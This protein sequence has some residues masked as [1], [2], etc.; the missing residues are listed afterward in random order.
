MPLNT[1]F[2]NMAQE[3]Y[4]ERYGMR[5]LAKT[6]KNLIL[7]GDLPL[8]QEWDKTISPWAMSPRMGENAHYQNDLINRCWM[9]PDI[10]TMKGI[11]ESQPFEDEYIVRTS[12]AAQPQ[13]EFP[14]IVMCG[15]GGQGVALPN[16][17]WTGRIS[18]DQEATDANFGKVKT[19]F[20]MLTEFEYKRLAWL[21]R[22]FV[23]SEGHNS[24]NYGTARWN[25]GSWYDLGD[26]TDAMYTD[27]LAGTKSIT[28]IKFVPYYASGESSP[29]ERRVI[30]STG[31]LSLA[32]TQPLDGSAEGLGI[33]APY[34]T[35]YIDYSLTAFANYATSDYENNIYTCALGSTGIGLSNFRCK[36]STSEWFASTAEWAD[37]RP[38]WG[39]DGN[40]TES[41]YFNGIGTDSTFWKTEGLSSSNWMYMYFR[42]R[43]DESLLNTKDKIRDYILTQAAYLG[44]WFVERS[45]IA[46]S[47]E[48]S[49]NNPDAY[50]GVI[51]SD[52]L[53]HGQYQKGSEIDAPNA[54]WVNP[55]EESPYIPYVPDPDPDPTDYDEELQTRLTFYSTD[56]SRGTADYLMTSQALGELLAVLSWYKT[57]EAAGDVPEGTCVTLFGTT[58]PLE[59]VSNI[60]LYP[61]DLDQAYPNWAGGGNGSPCGYTGIYMAANQG[62][63]VGNTELVVTDSPPTSDP[64]YIHVHSFSDIMQINWG[65]SIPVFECKSMG[66]FQRYKSFLDYEPY[67]SAELYVP[68]CGS[69]KIDPE[70]FT[71]Q[72]VGVMYSLS[73]TDG[74]VRADVYRNGLCVDSLTG[75]MGAQINLST[76]DIVSR[77]NAVQQL[78]AT[79]QAQ[80]ANAVKALAGFALGT[81]ATLATAGAAAP[82]TAALTAKSGIA[83]GSAALGAAGT[84]ES[85]HRSIQAA[86]YQVKNAEIPFKQLLTGG[87]FLSQIFEPAIRLVI[88]RP[89]CLP[90]YSRTNWGNYGHTTGF[91][92]LENSTLDNFSGLTVCS[93][94]DLSGVTCTAK[95]AEMIKSALKTGVYLPRYV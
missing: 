76:A 94:V 9:Y 81:A 21:I 24:P 65:N 6:Y 25:W 34:T 71:G 60:I 38:S 10:N 48:M 91:A 87:G 20:Y 30:S 74:S 53:T 67:C 26:I 8:N 28:G 54:D 52:G 33:N 95:E 45:G 85:A 77:A 43:L 93:S 39:V 70:L 7:D 66:Y 69:V 19:N 15:D 62:V 40:F 80:K 73:L 82:A 64:N 17:G 44:C 83:L 58:D 3:D 50:I 86:E 11:S 36:I 22:V 88:Y 1:D 31:F 57:A 14:F 68:F 37:G 47:S 23:A 18:P 29:N 72:S 46:M 75:N 16:P 41:R 5:R 42:Q 84:L 78:N 56:Q 49:K 59:C 61:V 51:E 92:C 12:I 2:W 79:I 89:T 4:P 90:G 35:D 27:I 55:W 32:D 63:Y 13:H